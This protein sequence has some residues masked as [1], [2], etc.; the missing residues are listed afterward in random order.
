MLN[1]LFILLIGLAFVGCNSPKQNIVGKWELLHMKDLSTGELIINDKADKSYLA[2]SSDR[3]YRN[4]ETELSFDSTE[5]AI[6]L[7]SNMEGYDYELNDMQVVLINVGYAPSKAIIPDGLNII[8]KNSSFIKYEIDRNQLIMKSLDETSM[9]F[10]YSEFPNQEF[11]YR[12]LSGGQN[13]LT[14][15]EIELKLKKL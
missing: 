9:K 11:V 2:I 4:Y 7:E 14:Q 1:R 6:L 15:H 10:S 13:I 12:K 8:K 3:F 5:N